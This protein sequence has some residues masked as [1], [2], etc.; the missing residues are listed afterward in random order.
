MTMHQD[1]SILVS[2]LTSNFH[3]M[4]A[5]KIM[6]SAIILFVLLL[7][8]RFMA[9]AQQD[10][11]VHG[12]GMLH[13]SV[14]NTGDLGR[15]LDNG[16]TKAI[17]GLPSFEWPASNGYPISLGSTDYIGYYN[18]F[19]GGFW[20]AADTARFVSAPSP[21]MY[22]QCGAC[23][24]NSGHNSPGGAIVTGPVQYITNFPLLSNGDVNP[25]YNPDEAEETILSSWDTPLGI[26]VTRT[27]RAWSHPDYDDFII[28]D[29]QL[30]NTGRH[31]WNGRSDTLRAITVAYAYS[32]GP[33][34][35]ADM[36]LNSGRWL[37]G[38]MRD[39]KA[40]ALGFVYGRFDWNRYMI[41]D[42]T[43]D[44]VPYQAGSD[45][46]LT[47]PGAI[48]ILPL[49]YD[50]SHLA[51]KGSVQVA[52]SNASQPSDSVQL[53]DSNDKLKQPYN[54]S[55]DNGNLSLDKFKKYLDIEQQR[56][57]TPFRN[58]SDSTTFGTYWIGRGKPNWSSNLRNPTGKV[59]G[60][61]PYTLN[62]G[63][64]M[65]F[66]VAEVA[67]FGARTPGYFHDT[68]VDRTADKRRYFDLGG[69]TGGN[70][71]ATP[72]P[73]I[74]PVPSWWDTVYYDFMSDVYPDRPMGSL[75]MQSHALPAYVNSANVVSI[76]DVADRAIQLYTGWPLIDYDTTQFEPLSAPSLGVYRIPIIC[77]APVITVA[78]INPNNIPIASNQITWGPQVET[79]TRSTPG[80]SRLAA[81]LSYYQVIRA[82]SPI[83]PWTV[84]DSVGRLDSRYF[85]GSEYVFYDQTCQLLSNY[86]YAVV[87]VDSLGGKSSITN[88]TFHSTQLPAVIKLGKV[89][90]APNPFI[91]SSHYG[92][93]KND[94]IGFFGLPENAT[95]RVFSYSGQLVATIEHRSSGYGEE[96]FQLSR[97]NQWIASGV[98]YFVVDDIDRGD[99]SWGKFVV[100]H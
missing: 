21:R 87:S 56:Y 84:L 47:A 40:G 41:Y 5:G 3:I 67:G 60:F 96:W 100:I 92:D 9:Y 16:S 99:R 83:G 71:P 88:M 74:E 70:D 28:Y 29:Y 53:W 57:N 15:P 52:L 51:T 62:P 22:V 68:T 89:Y 80:F 46:I 63:E 65:H 24:D 82:T 77:P 44:G 42:H 85:N 48:G 1:R 31:S 14:F 7:F 36:L 32:L 72:P 97:N 11:K 39:D 38:S 61:G 17:Q 4:R 98:Y 13:Q 54:I 25:A 73:G 49:Y 69:N 37:E 55:Y 35:I 19:G 33:S 90:A 26:T 45:T 81:P 91:V 58:S 30:T 59:Y 94:R 93:N 78:S 27:S 43:I 75:Y 23:T 66:V 34:M 95:I 86:F 12:R 79:I 18:S 64:T 8:A 2:L 6:R 20:I 10:Y 76:R 50:Y